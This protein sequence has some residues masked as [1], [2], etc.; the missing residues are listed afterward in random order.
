MALLVIRAQLWFLTCMLFGD[1]PTIITGKIDNIRNDHSNNVAPLIIISLFLSLF[2]LICFTGTGHSPLNGKT[3]TTEYLW[4]IQ[5]A[6][7]MDLL[8]TI[9]MAFLEKATVSQIEWTQYGN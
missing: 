1:L 3:I 8:I 6:M 7:R 9:R 2:P 4:P 5:L